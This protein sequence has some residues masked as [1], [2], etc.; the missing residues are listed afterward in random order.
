MLAGYWHLARAHCAGRGLGGCSGRRPI[1]SA[2]AQAVE[3]HGAVSGRPAADAPAAAGQDTPRGGAAREVWPWAPCFREGQF[4]AGAWSSVAAG[5]GPARVGGERSDFRAT[6]ALSRSCAD[7]PK[8]GVRATRGAGGAAEQM[9]PSRPVSILLPDANDRHAVVTS[10]RR[11]LDGDSAT[12][13][14]PGKPRG[15]RQFRTSR[16]VRGGDHCLTNLCRVQSGLDSGGSHR[17]R[18]PG[19]TRA[20]RS[21]PFA[22]AP[23]PSGA[24]DAQGGSRAESSCKRPRLRRG[25]FAAVLDRLTGTAA[26]PGGPGRDRRSVTRI[27][28]SET[29]AQF[30]M[31]RRIAAAGQR[32]VGRGLAI[33]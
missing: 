1:T 21:Y 4:A 12:S 19:S 8:S 24:D 3:D 15:P 13:A 10:V 20:S 14:T 26:V 18:P 30:P 32:L 33:S 28:A 27:M 5:S 6:W 17:S 9:A 2:V 11:A 23:M 22:P 29:S 7:Y 25:A 31:P 16:R